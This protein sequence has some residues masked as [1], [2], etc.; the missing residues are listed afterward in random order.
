MNP[1]LP[2]RH[3]IWLYMFAAAVGAALF[4]LAASLLVGPPQ[5]G[6][7]PGPTQVVGLTVAA[8]AV[9]AWAIWLSIRAFRDLDEFHREAGKFAWYWG[10]SLGLGVSLIG[11]VFLVTGGLHWLDAAAAAG[12]G[13]AR[14]FRQGYLL[15]LG[16]QVAGFLAVRLWWQ[17]AKR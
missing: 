8:A 16:S 2:R 4:V 13:P 3:S 7:P 1:D 14:A 17:A 5:P 6:R 11:Y 9:V 10:G 15:A 12:P